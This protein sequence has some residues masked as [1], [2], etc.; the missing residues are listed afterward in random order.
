MHEGEKWKWSSSV[1][2]DSE[3]PH[4]LQPTGL[5]RPQDFPGK[6]TGVGCHRLLHSNVELVVK[7]LPGG[8]SDKEPACQFRRCKR[9]RFNPWVKKIPWRRA[10]QPILVHLTG[11][12]HGQRRLVGYCPWGS[13]RVGH[14]WSDLAQHTAAHD[15]LLSDENPVSLI[16]FFSS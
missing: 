7:N 5:L 14:N 3:R 1:L 15:I 11:E 8:T 9:C 12:S 4:G 2:Y 6:S 10:W 13:Q 16:Y